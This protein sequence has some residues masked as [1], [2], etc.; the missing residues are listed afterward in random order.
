MGGETASWSRPA[1]QALISQIRA[2]YLRE[3]GQVPELAWL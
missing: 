2:V 1:V 3:Y